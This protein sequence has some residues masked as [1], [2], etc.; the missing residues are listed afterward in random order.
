MFYH[1]ILREPSLA[2]G[3]PVYLCAVVAFP[4]HLGWLGVSWAGFASYVL[5]A[6]ALFAVVDFVSQ[7]SLYPSL[8]SVVPQTLL[9]FLALAVPAALMFAIGAA[10]GPLDETLGEEVCAAQGAMESDTPEAESDDL[11]DV[12]ADCIGDR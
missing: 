7:R 4:L 9:S 6:A 5:L 12:T 1:W 11:F 3:I 10:L 8:T 2:L